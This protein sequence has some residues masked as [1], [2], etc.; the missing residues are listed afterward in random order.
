MCGLCSIV[1]SLL[2]LFTWDWVWMLCWNS[3]CSCSLQQNQLI[4]RLTPI[5]DRHVILFTSLGFRVQGVLCLLHTSLKATSILASPKD[6]KNIYFCSFQL[7]PYVGNE[8]QRM[9]EVYVSVLLLQT[10]IWIFLSPCSTLVQPSLRWAPSGSS[11]TCTMWLAKARPLCC[12]PKARGSAN[13][14]IYSRLSQSKK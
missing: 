13:C 2:L 5:G 7:G 9:S 4:T 3:T 10:Y 12:S 8:W 14:R 6:K 11:Y 1:L